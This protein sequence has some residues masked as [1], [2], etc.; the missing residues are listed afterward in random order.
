MITAAT[1]IANVASLLSFT[2]VFVESL[3]RTIACVVAGLL[4]T[5]LYVPPAADVPATMRLQIEPAFV[6]YSIF[7]RLMLWLVHVIDR[8]LPIAHTSPPFG[9]VTVTCG[10]TRIVNTPLLESRTEASAIS[11]ILT[12]PLLV[13]VFATVQ[14]YVA[15][16]D[17]TLAAIVFHVVPAFVLYSKATFE[18]FALVHVMF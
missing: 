17:G 13:A 4:T 7:T 15:G 16:V 5:Q 14:A 9:A 1:C 6:L 10:A 2:L 8:A 3:T 11:T 12:S 18:T